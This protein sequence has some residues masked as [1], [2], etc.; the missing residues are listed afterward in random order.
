MRA[1]RARLREQTAEQPPA[2]P[3]E[4]QTLLTGQLGLLWQPAARPQEEKPY[5]RNTDGCTGDQPA[6]DP[7]GVRLEKGKYPALRLFLGSE[8]QP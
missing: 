1:F 7:L 4:L 3:A 5:D 8:A 6:G 2:L